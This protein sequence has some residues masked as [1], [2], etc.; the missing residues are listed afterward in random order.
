MKYLFLFFAVT[1]TAE[2]MM[3]AAGGINMRTIGTC[4][5]S[6]GKKVYLVKQW[7]LAGSVDSHDKKD[8]PQAKNQQAIFHELKKWIETKKIDTVFS[9]GCEGVIDEKF[10]PVFNGWSYSELKD[11]K[12]SPKFEN[13]IT[14]VPLKL[15]VLFGDKLQT[16]CGDSLP[17]IKRGELALSDLRGFLGLLGKISQPKDPDELKSFS[18]LA[19]K[20][21]RM[22]PNSTT[23]QIRKTLIERMKAAL[24]T[25]RDSLEKRNASFLTAIKGTEFK[26]AAVVIGGLHVADLQKKLNAQGFACEVDEPEGYSAPDESLLNQL[27]TMIS[28]KY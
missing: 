17:E 22:S 18:D 3:P 1:A 7:H 19:I 13:A 24:D 27:E 8:L 10:K 11:A 4:S 23:A 14:L 25:Y 20:L 16:K 26:N 15:E 6:I 2:N 9:E 28:S 21:L 12:G 5:K